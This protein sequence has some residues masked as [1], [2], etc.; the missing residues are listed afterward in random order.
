MKAWWREFKLLACA[1][2]ERGFQ[3]IVLDDGKWADLIPRGNRVKCLAA[4]YGDIAIERDRQ[5]G[6]ALRR[7][8]HWCQRLFRRN[9]ARF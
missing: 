6:L 3:L 8:D 4:H 9:G 2:D 5:D 1:N 7:S